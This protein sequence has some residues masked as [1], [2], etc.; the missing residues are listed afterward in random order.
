MGQ[1]DIGSGLLWAVIKDGVQ[2]YNSD[3]VHTF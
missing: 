3:G 2:Q 1:W